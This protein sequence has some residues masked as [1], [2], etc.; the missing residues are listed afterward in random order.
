LYLDKIWLCLFFVQVVVGNMQEQFVVVV[1]QIW[2]CWFCVAVAVGNMQE[3]F[4]V[5]VGQIWLCWFCVAV[6]V[7]NMHEQLPLCCC[8]LL[9]ITYYKYHM[10][11]TSW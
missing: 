9:R 3:Q 1:G 6:A 8:N 5:V 4:V 11:P 7:G 10:I 2:L